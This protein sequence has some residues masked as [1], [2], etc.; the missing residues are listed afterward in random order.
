MGTVA[1]LAQD[2]ASCLRRLVNEPVMTRGPNE[3]DTALR[4]AVSIGN[5]ASAASLLKQGAGPNSWRLLHL[6]AKEGHR[7]VTA[8]ILDYGTA[9]DVCDLYH[10][11]ALHLAAR[12]GHCDVVSLLIDRGA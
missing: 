4:E 2:A 11:Q 3:L 5:A 1:I 12:G 9:V 7:D 6:A 8:L 10:Q